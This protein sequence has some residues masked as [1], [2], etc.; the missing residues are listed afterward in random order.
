[1]IRRLSINEG[2]VES[3]HIKLWFCTFTSVLSPRRGSHE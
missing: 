2:V 1:M 3:Y